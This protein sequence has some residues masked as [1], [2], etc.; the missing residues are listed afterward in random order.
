MEAPH[1]QE[2]LLREE[3][4]HFFHRELDR[5]YEDSYLEQIPEVAEAGLFKTVPREQIER[6]K[7]FFK[8]VMY[9]VGSAREERDRGVETVA[10]LLESTSSLISL[11]PQLPTIVLR[12]DIRIPAITGA[13]LH[14]VASYRRA[15][16]LEEKVLHR[17]QELCEEEEIDP[18]QDAEVPPPL[19]R[20][21]YGSLEER[22]TDKMLDDIK[23]IVRLGMRESLISSTIDI[24]S[25]VEDSRKSREEQD[26]LSYVRSV[27]E[28]VRGLSR[29]YT[30]AQVKEVLRLSEMTER[31]YFE[32]L[33]TTAG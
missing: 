3:L 24:V 22:E 16:H 9:P 7:A 6:I 28:E 10:A 21:A 31:Y 33:R 20:E 25:R 12:H 14:V 5:R 2:T 32:Q 27:L 19:F 30:E 23:R 4:G 17:L 18:A 29:A 26:A 1:E 15:R 13:G 11:L 8:Q